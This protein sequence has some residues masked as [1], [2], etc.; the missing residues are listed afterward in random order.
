MTTPD[1]TV[2]ISELRARVSNHAK[3]DGDNS[4]GAISTITASI[5]KINTQYI[6]FYCTPQII[7]TIIFIIM[8]PN[9]VC[10]EY[11]DK[12]NVVTNRLNYNRVLI[13]GLISGTVISVG[14]FA[15]F[16]SKKVN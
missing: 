13:A 1:Y 8:K 5:P 15:Y 16:H 12:D 2:K 10:N 7:L 4:I 3:L 11:I 6:L 9:F 14:L